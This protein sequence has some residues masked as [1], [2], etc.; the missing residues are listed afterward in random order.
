M[1]RSS[2]VLT[3]SALVFVSAILLSAALAYNTAP[4]ASFELV[5]QNVLYIGVD[6]PILIAVHDVAPEDVIV[7]LKGGTVTKSG[8]R[9][10]AYILRV[11][12]GF[13]TDLSVWYMK[14][15][16][17]Y[18]AGSYHLRIKKIPDPVTYVGNIRHEGIMLKNDLQNISGVFTRMEN[19][20]FDY[21]FRPQSFTM[22]LFHDSTWTDYKATGPACTPEMKA[23]LK[24]AMPEDKI[25]FHEVVTMGLDS[26]LRKTNAVLITVK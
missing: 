9:P 8:T 5:K 16:A 24:S 18:S 3:L 20:D 2:R 11:E 6:N 13:S 12:Q 15:S 10:G 1:S 17:K 19:F 22:S 21:A 4:S 26:S 14:D 23:A 25:I 7:E